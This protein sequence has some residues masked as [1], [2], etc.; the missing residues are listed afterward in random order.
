[1]GAIA[2]I[3]DMGFMAAAGITIFCGVGLLNTCEYTP[4]S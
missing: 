4:L 2:R 1:M 3:V